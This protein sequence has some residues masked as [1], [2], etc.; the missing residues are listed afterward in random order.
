MSVSHCNSYDSILFFSLFFCNPTETAMSLS[1][2]QSG[3]LAVVALVLV[4]ARSTSAYV[5]AWDQPVLYSCTNGKILKSVQSIHSNGAEDRRWQFT[6]GSA[7]S[8]AS[9]NSC[10]WTSSYVNTW[11]EP[12]S[13]MCAADHVITGVSS[14]HSNGAEDR[15]YKFKC[16]KH[17]GY[18]TYSCSLTSYLNN[19]DARLSYS[20]PAGKVIAGWASW[21]SNGSEDRRHKMLTCSYG[22]IN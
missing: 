17:Q 12:I 2:K 6:C 22:R 10:Y 19:W 3:Y 14:Y 5:N 15:R 13:F 7:P 11:D 20:V 9:P 4:L 21:H 8:N 16:C 18:K 1:V